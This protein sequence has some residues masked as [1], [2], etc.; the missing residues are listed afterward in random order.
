MSGPLDDIGPSPA[1]VDGGHSPPT[2]VSAARKALT[3][4]LEERAQPEQPRTHNPWG[5]EE[6]VDNTTT[7]P[8]VSR[9]AKIA[10]AVALGLVAVYVLVSL[11]FVVPAG[12]FRTAMA[13]VLTA[14]SPYFAQKWNVFAP[15]IMKANTELRFQAQWRDDSGQLVKSEWVNLTEIEQNSVAGNAI[16]S[17]IQKSSWNA[18]LAYNKRYAL[19]TSDQ[20]RIVRDTFIERTDD[21]FRAKLVEP[22]LD[23]LST[24]GSS[25]SATVR[26]LRYDYMLKEYTTDFAT[27]YFGKDIE[28]VRWQIH[29]TRPNDF[30]HRF[31]SAQQFDESNVT[32]GWRQA[33]DVIDPDVIAVYSDVIERYA[34]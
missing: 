20:K 13:P 12:A 8:P 21:G 29:R 14:A 18:T 34:R 3:A 19:L 9:N 5:G 24:P 4:P 28:R 6:Q 16:P 32:F 1:R 26:F 2:A 22:L 15:N 7:T 23:E 30:D 27:A 25:T 33:D 31:D 17:R 10:S 11:A